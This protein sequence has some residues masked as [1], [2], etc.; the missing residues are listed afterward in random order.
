MLGRHIITTVN[1]RVLSLLVK[2]S[3]REFYERQ[4]ARR[5][6]VGYGSANRALNELYSTGAIRRRQEGKMYFYYAGISNPA[7]I[8]LKKLVN[9]L[10]IEPL[11]EELKN[12]SSRVVL[13]GSCAQG[14]DTSDSD[15]D[16]FVVSDNK[17]E[18]LE[19]VDSFR[20]PRG[21]EGIHIQIVVK[22]PV[23]LLET[24]GVGQAF[25]EEVEHGIVLWERVASESR[26]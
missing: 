15:F 25:I 7:I 22:T 8:E 21:F 17:E 18:V 11:V 2:F 23:E 6:S 26:V 20:F 1:Q 24:E 9:L 19:A 13:Y 14:T 5:I 16:L 4:I 3:D 10:L 12:I